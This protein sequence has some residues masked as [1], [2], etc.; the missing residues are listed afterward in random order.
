MLSASDNELLSRVGPGTPMGDLMRRFWQPILL[1]EELPQRDGEPVRVRLLGED[2]V[3]FRDTNGNVGMIDNYCPHRRASLFFGRNE[4][5]GLRCVYHGWK[6]DINGDCVDM[7][8]EPAESNFKDKVRITAYPTHEAGDCIFVYMGPKEV[9]PPF[10]HLEWTRVPSANRL[11]MRWIQDS[12]YMQTI[13][14][15]LDTAHVSFL[16]RWFDPKDRPQSVAR[17]IKNGQDMTVMDGSPRL[18]VEETDY[19]FIYGSRRDIGDGEY[20]WRATQFILPAYNLIPGPSWP[21]TG[22]AWIPIDDDHTSVFSFTYQPDEPLDP[23]Q[24]EG[25]KASTM[26]MERVKHKTVDGKI[27]DGW[28]DVRNSSN[29]YLVDRELQKKTNFT[30]IPY[31][32]TQDEAMTDSMGRIVDRTKEHL[33][34]SDTAIIHA[35]RQL[36]R[37]A[38]ELQEGIEPSVAQHAE[39]FNV[40]AIDVV[41][42]TADFKEL[43]AKDGDL[44]KGTV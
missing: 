4:E 29:D 12:N 2:M 17:R 26:Q 34:T 14:G 43:L 10:P 37:M 30:G 32:R 8:S 31:G 35:R 7:P 28:H 40:R 1:S 39:A 44:A 3:A 6:F 13:E 22:H 20:Y 23:T 19:G 5:C 21:I 24:V 27:I 33:G 25:R 15:D 16:H 38:R 42:T 36:L 9:Q 41:N 18:H 11:M